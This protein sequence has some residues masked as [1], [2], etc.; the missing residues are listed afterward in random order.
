MNGPSDCKRMSTI[1]AIKDHNATRTASHQKL[2]T[3]V[4]SEQKSNRVDNA[5]PGDKNPD[6]IIKDQQLTQTVEM[7]T[8][9]VVLSSSDL[10]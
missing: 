9:R 7:E 5:P 6:D 10:Q 3:K 1:E 4:S 2:D 8:D